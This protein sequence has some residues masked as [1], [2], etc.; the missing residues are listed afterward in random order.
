MRILISELDHKSIHDCVEIC[1][2][3]VYFDIGNKKI[4][5]KG[6]RI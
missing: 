3:I 2:K 6:K 4:L 5:I 1:G